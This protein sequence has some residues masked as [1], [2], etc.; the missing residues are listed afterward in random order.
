MSDQR[1]ETNLRTLCPWPEDPSHFEAAAFYAE[2]GLP[3]FPLR[4]RGKEPM[5]QH[6]FKD[7]TT[8]PKQVRCWWTQN[9]QANIGIPTGSRSGIVVVDV[10]GPEGRENLRKLGWAIVT[11]TSIT[12]RGF[13]LL[14]EHPGH[15]IPSIQRLAPGIDVK[16]DGGYIVAP[17]SLHET[18]SRYRWDEANAMGWEA[19]IAPIPPSVVEHLIAAKRW[20]VARFTLPDRIPEGERNETIFKYGCSLRSKGASIEKIEEALRRAN[21]ERCTSPLGEHEVMKTAKGIGRYAVGGSPE[22]S[23]RVAEPERLLELAEEAE[24]FHAPDQTA[25]VTLHD[26]GHH[27]THPID[28]KAFRNWLRYRYFAQFGRAPHSQPLQDAMATLEARAQF[29]G[30]EHEVYVRVGQ[31]GDRLYID[32]GD[33]SCR[34]VEVTP[35]GW[36]IIEHPGVPFRRARGMSQLP[37]P[38]AGGSVELLCNHF[39]LND[40]DDVRVVVAW[41]IAALRP[42]GPFPVLVIQGEQGSSKSTTAR[43]IRELVDPARPPLRTVPQDERDL[44]IAARNNWVL[45]FDNVSVVQPWL[46]DGLCRLA[47]GGGLA[48]R[49]LYTNYEEALFEAQRPIILNSIAD[50]LHRDDLRDRALAITLPPIPDHARRS[51]SDFWRE[52]RAEM[53]LV[54]GAL[55]DGICSALRDSPMIELTHPPRMADFAHWAT[56]AEAGLGWKR[57]TALAA[58]TRN[59]DVS[60]AAFIEAN[61][62][63]AAILA[64]VPN[65][66]WL[67]TAT[68]LLS[69]L[70]EYVDA[71]VQERKSWPRAAHVLS[72][73]L[74]KAAPALRR[75]G[76]EIDRHHG[77]DRIITITRTTQMTVGSVES[78]GV[79]MADVASD[80][81]DTPY[82]PST[83][84]ADYEEE[85]RIAIQDE[86]ALVDPKTP[87]VSATTGVPPDSQ[88]GGRL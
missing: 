45:A 51:E 13:H 60:V 52:Y 36:R 74:T 2:H 84:D 17:P 71:K 86:G 69:E 6:G 28:S 26:D 79:K 73:R 48:T 37:T 70:N 31:A 20:N 4:P 53:P 8:N 47:S 19:P 7:A 67:G 35:Q 9:P 75:S 72:G 50:V 54:L 32:L 22:Q 65:A 24:L 64:W 56:A 43:A 15:F 81:S 68:Q 76:I 30:D 23:G 80:A 39:N 78:V 58:I 61:D 10:D 27:A 85:E 12:G 18:D 59:R 38:I 34:A 57:G 62:V 29:E 42:Q 5:T 49:E 16:G 11:R 66:G 82:S 83:V 55:L 3:V 41:L 1:R 14:F 33:S 63:A 77:T 88:S 46:S 87:E 21:T 25:Y 40:D 44:M